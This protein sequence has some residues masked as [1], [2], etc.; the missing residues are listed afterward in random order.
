LID[1]INWS[2]NQNDI[3]VTE[4]CSFDPT[5]SSAGKLSKIITPGTS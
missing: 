5:V 3:V 2:G 1:K 4:R